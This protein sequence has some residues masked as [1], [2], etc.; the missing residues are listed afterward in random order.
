MKNHLQ[1]ISLKYSNMEDTHFVPKYVSIG[2]QTDQE[3]VR[4]KK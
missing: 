1:D 2:V 3:E 4:I